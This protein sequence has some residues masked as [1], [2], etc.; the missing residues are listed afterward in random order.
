MSYPDRHLMSLRTGVFEP[1]FSIDRP[2]PAMCAAI[3]CIVIA[4]LIITVG[5]FLGSVYDADAKSSSSSRSRPEHGEATKRRGS[6]VGNADHRSRWREQYNASAEGEGD[7]FSLD[8]EVSEVVEPTPATRYP[9][10]GTGEDITWAR[11]DSVEDSAA[12]AR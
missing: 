10:T 1:W 8:E 12:A 11:W 5:K 7:V 4:F 6:D 2:S 3:F 9:S